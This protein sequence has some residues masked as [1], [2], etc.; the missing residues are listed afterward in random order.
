M[1][2]QSQVGEQTLHYLFRS[3]SNSHHQHNVTLK[4]MHCVI[5]TLACYVCTFQLDT[6]GISKL[7]KLYVIF[8]RGDQGVANTS[9]LAHAE[10]HTQGSSS[11]SPLT[12]G[13]AINFTTEVHQPP[14]SRLLCHAG[15]V[16]GSLGLFFLLPL[17]HS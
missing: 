11:T 4:T 13:A 8:V 15:W 2:E 7:A 5:F 6:S 3:F 17:G 14:I 9:K 12:D 1:E 10:T 16:F